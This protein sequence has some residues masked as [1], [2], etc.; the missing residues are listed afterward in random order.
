M[1]IVGSSPELLIRCEDGV[2]ETRPIAGTRPG[3]EDEDRTRRLPGSLGRRPK[4][5]PSTSCWS[6]WGVN[7][8]GRVCEQGTVQITEFMNIEKYSHVMHI[9]SNVRESSR[10][11]KDGLD[12]LQAAFPAGTVSGARRSGR[13]KSSMNWKRLTAARTRDASGISVSREIW[14]RVSP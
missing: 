2:V 5:R 4:R 6:I 12:V 8:L 14:I 13:W 1:R 11:D 10:K 7:D 3:G 9:V